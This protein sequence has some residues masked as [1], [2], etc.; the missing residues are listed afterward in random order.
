MCACIFKTLCTR[1]SWRT[2]RGSITCINDSICL[3]RSYVCVSPACEKWRSIGPV[4][5]VRMLRRIR[6]PNVLCRDAIVFT[7]RTN[8][9]FFCSLLFKILYTCMLRRK[10][11][12]GGHSVVELSQ[13]H[14]FFS[15]FFFFC[16]FTSRPCNLF[17]AFVN[18][19]TLMLR[20]RSVRIA[21]VFGSCNGVRITRVPTF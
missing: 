1:P 4:K 20:T 9:F 13:D 17:D 8:F 10:P 12:S 7:D 11:Y 19:L 18:L 16:P 5:R 6:K 2:N 21:V 15:F 14:F 3:L